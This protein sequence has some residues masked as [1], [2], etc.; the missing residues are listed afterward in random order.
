MMNLYQCEAKAQEIGF[1]KANFLAIFPRGPVNCRWID[2]YMGL[3]EI[4]LD[5]MR[6]S[7]V[8]TKQIDELYPNL[9]CLE[10]WVE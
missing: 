2:A 9:V 6:G 5:G 7:F 8:T 1:D 3:F 10:P 4:D